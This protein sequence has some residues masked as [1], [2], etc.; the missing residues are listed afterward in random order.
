MPHF[1]GDPPAPCPCAPAP[2]PRPQTQETVD[3]SCVV[4]LPLEAGESETFGQK[5]QP[6]IFSRIEKVLCTTQD[7]SATLR[8]VEAQRHTAPRAAGPSLFTQ[9]TLH[10]AT[11]ERL[12]SC[13]CCSKN[14]GGITS[15]VICLPPSRAGTK[16]RQDGGR[17]HG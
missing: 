1:L 2:C 16:D 8:G 10:E 11:A 9:H 12:E 17:K 4:G 6:K 3:G 5:G 7:P 15:A 13:H 14:E